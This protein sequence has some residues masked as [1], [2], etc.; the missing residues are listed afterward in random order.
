MSMSLGAPVRADRTMKDKYAVDS[1]LGWAEVAAVV[2]RRQIAVANDAGA[3][4]RSIME[5]RKMGL[6]EHKMQSV[7]RDGR[8]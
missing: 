1:Y 4:E 2:V 7:Y 3:D 8:T 5:T 6:R